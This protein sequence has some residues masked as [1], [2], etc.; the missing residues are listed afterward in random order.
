MAAVG[1]GIL[2]S[3]LEAADEWLH[4]EHVAEPDL[5]SVALY[6]E[7]YGTYSQLYPDLKD[8][9][10]TTSALIERLSS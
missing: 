2:P 3:V 9:F 1:V 10:A 5:S 7:F 6:N 4:I 8:R